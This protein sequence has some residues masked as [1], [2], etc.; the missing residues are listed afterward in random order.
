MPSAEAAVEYAKSIIT[1]LDLNIRRLRARVLEVPERFKR[2]S[3]VELDVCR[4]EGWKDPNEGVAWS[5]FQDPGQCASEVATKVI[6]LLR[7]RENK[8]REVEMLKGE[9]R[10][11]LDRAAEEE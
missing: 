4:A 9:L 5:E 2:I 10:F 3:H 7:E 8:E 1:P 11:R 6:E